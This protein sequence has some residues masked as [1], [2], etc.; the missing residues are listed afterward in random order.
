M[1][2]GSTIPTVIAAIRDGLAAVVPV[3][4]E[5]RWGRP[6]DSLVVR[7]A[8]YV[9]DFDLQS[10]IPTIKAGRKQREERYTFDVVFWEAPARGTVEAALT[11]ALANYDLLDD[12]LADDPT[13]TNLDGLVSATLS[14][15]GGRAQQSNEGPMAEITATVSVHA[16][17]V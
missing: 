15:A 3:G 11:Q 7:H 1:A 9:G 2:T 17:L 8:V 5:V 4:T 14:V 12:L 13:L 6:A 16:R 10:R